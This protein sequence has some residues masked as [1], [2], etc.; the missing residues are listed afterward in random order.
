MSGCDDVN[1]SM[2]SAFRNKIKSV[3]RAFLDFPFPQAWWSLNSPQVTHSGLQITPPSLP[4]TE[5]PRKAS[6]PDFILITLT[7][8]PTL[9]ACYL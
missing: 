8:Q 1:L 9:I 6:S 4:G 2:F 3:D 7:N 5:S